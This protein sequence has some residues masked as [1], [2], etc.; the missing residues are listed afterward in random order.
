MTAYWPI[1]HAYQVAVLLDAIG[2][3]ACVAP[4]IG[5]HTQYLA[6]QCLEHA[7]QL[8]GLGYDKFIDTV[9]FVIM[10]KQGCSQGVSSA[11]TVE[12]LIARWVDHLS[13]MKPGLAQYRLA[14]TRLR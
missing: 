3:V 11:I 2:D 5:F 9:G 1:Q 13:Y 8:I 4:S 10:A 7:R 12:I 14:E 6:C